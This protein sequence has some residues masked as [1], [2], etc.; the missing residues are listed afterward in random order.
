MIAVLCRGVHT[1]ALSILFGADDSPDPAIGV[2]AGV[3]GLLA[4]VVGCLVGTRTEQV[5]ATR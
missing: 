2:W 1:Y 4:P 5:P 3:A